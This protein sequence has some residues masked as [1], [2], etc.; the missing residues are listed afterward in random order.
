[1]IDFAVDET[2][3]A[4]IMSLGFARSHAI[5]ALRETDNNVER[6]ADWVFNHPVDSTEEMD[7]APSAERSETGI[8]EQDRNET[9]FR[10]S[11]SKIVRIV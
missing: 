6:A 7:V 9:N 2:A 5:R 1:M 10:K 4:T 3:L 11:K 8:G